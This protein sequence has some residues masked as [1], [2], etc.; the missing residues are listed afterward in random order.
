MKQ[1]DHLGLSPKTDGAGS[2]AGPML[3]DKMKSPDKRE[4]DQD[5]VQCWLLLCWTKCLTSFPVVA[6]GGT[7]VLAVRDSATG[8]CRSV[9]R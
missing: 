2:P 1:S 6:G 5:R 7:E 8:Y 4:R 9:L 3:I